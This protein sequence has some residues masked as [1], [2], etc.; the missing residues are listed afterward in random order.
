[1]HPK[2]HPRPMPPPI[3][4]D[5]ADE[6]SERYADYEVAKENGASPVAKPCSAC[7][8][9]A[10]VCEMDPDEDEQICTRCRRDERVCDL[11]LLTTTLLRNERITRGAPLDAAQD[12]QKGADN[13]TEEAPS[14]YYI[15]DDTSETTSRKR[16]RTVAG[17]GSMAPPPPRPTLHPCGPATATTAERI[18]EL[19]ESV[20]YI[21]TA[22]FQLR[23]EVGFLGNDLDGQQ[24]S[25]EHLISE[26]RRKM[27]KL[28]GGMAT[29]VG[30]VEHMVELMVKMMEEKML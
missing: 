11:T 10:V 18:G 12:A 1:M 8:Y 14:F 27:E 24:C 30:N 13:A 29:M 9:W 17:P 3:T 16:R 23:D 15:E 25:T 22:V 4:T 28:F 19:A 5:M 6:R 26:M 20:A 7:V 2:Q 21:Q